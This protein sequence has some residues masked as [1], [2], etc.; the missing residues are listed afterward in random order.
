MQSFSPT[1]LDEVKYDKLK[2]G[3]CIHSSKICVWGEKESSTRARSLALHGVAWRN[4]RAHVNGPPKS[5]PS[6]CEGIVSFLLFLFLFTWLLNLPR[7][8]ILI[9]F[10]RQSLPK[11][12]LI[13][14][15]FCLS[16]LLRCLRSLLHPERRRASANGRAGL[17]NRSLS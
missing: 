8:G 7:Y 9:G 6:P 16:S 13:E 5:G 3:G 11:H 1:F 4:T 17:R 14:L 15:G 10:T 12:D 2:Y